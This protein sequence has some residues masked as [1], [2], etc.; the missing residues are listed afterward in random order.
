MSD[1][2]NLLSNHGESNLND[3]LAT[4]VNDKKSQNTCSLSD[5]QNQ[6]APDKNSDLRVEN[7]KCFK[8]QNVG[9]TVWECPLNKQ[10]IKNKTA[11]DYSDPESDENEGPPMKRKIP[12]TGYE[13]SLPKLK[14]PIQSTEKVVGQNTPQRQ[15]RNRSEIPDWI[16]SAECWICH[17]K[18]HLR[19]NCPNRRFPDRY[20]VLNYPSTR[21]LCRTNRRQNQE[22]LEALF[23][24]MPLKR[25]EIIIKL[26]QISKVRNSCSI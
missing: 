7:Q 17:M 24:R 23:K 16:K 21:Y 4:R 19:R 8:C 6:K 26:I 2:Q 18:G 5:V 14:T 25:E 11:L 3:Q 15:G 9:H 22:N 1:N 10:C 13:N 12:L 20:R